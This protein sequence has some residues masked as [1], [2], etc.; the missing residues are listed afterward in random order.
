MKIMYLNGYA[1]VAPVMP[2]SMD[3]SVGLFINGHQDNRRGS[4]L[5]ARVRLNSSCQPSHFPLVLLPNR[6]TG[7]PFL[8]LETYRTI[9]R[10]YAIRACQ[11]TPDIA[12]TKSCCDEFFKRE[13]WS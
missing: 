13:K 2:V 4:G 8:Q 7:C 6:H 9:A 10:E 5:N 12:A 3:S 1:I 11:S